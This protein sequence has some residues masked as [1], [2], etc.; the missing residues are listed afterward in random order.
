[1]EKDRLACRYLVADRLSCRDPCSL[2][3]NGGIASMQVQPSNLY[4][5]QPKV[6]DEDLN[7]TQKWSSTGGSRTPSE[8]SPSSENKRLTYLCEAFGW[9]GGIFSLVNLSA[10]T[11]KTRVAGVVIALGRW[12]MTGVEREK[13]TPTSAFF[14]R[15]HSWACSR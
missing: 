13:M 15:T 4:Y 12:P 10:P 11:K 1:M 9:S 5:S 3:Y 7:E 6:C 14:Q 8:R 2:C